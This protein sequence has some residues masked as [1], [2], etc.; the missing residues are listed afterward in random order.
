MGC[1]L[2]KGVQPRRQVGAE[3]SSLSIPQTQ[4]SPGEEGPLPN[5]HKGSALWPGCIF[6]AQCPSTEAPVDQQCGGCSPPLGPTQVQEG[7]GWGP[8]FRLL[9]LQQGGPVGPAQSPPGSRAEPPPPLSLYSALTPSLW[10]SPG[11][12]LT[13]AGPTWPCECLKPFPCPPAPAE[14][15]QRLVMPGRLDPLGP[16]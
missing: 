14:R 15:G 3:T 1:S 2:H 9:S 12:C 6:G 7:W 8:G 4:C 10:A 16:W 11:F 13:T 5:S